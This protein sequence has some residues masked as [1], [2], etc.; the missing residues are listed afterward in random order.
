MA[1]T[2]QRINDLQQIT[3]GLNNTDMMLIARSNNT[4]TS[5]VT[6]SV[7]LSTLSSAAWNACKDK[8]FEISVLTDIASC[9]GNNSRV[10][11]ANLTY[12]NYLSV[13]GLQTS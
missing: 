11:A 4:K 3:N 5:Y 10:A 1:Y 8:N 12:R 13:V 2:Y 6:Y 9:N 7:A